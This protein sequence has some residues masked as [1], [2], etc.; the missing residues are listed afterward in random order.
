LIDR[1]LAWRRYTK[2]QARRNHKERLSTPFVS[3]EQSRLS[4]SRLLVDQ[5]L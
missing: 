3:F 4:R 2:Q 1:A 5:K